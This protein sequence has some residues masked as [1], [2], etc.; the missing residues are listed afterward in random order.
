MNER[1]NNKNNKKATIT[2]TITTIVFFI[3]RGM[4]KIPISAPTRLK[5]NFY[6]NFNYIIII[7]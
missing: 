5:G 3:T 6:K 7:Y 1:Y 4:F 2:T